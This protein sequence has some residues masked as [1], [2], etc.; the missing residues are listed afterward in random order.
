MEGHD[1]DPWSSGRDLHSCEGDRSRREES[2]GD[3]LCYSLPLE[4]SGEVGAIKIDFRLRNDR[5][6]DKVPQQQGVSGCTTTFRRNTRE[7]KR[8]A[9]TGRSM[10]KR[11]VYARVYH[12]LQSSSPATIAHFLCTMLEPL[13]LCSTP[14]SLSPGLLPRDTEGWAHLE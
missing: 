5:A 13:L 7:R 4:L 14:L 10:R 11:L 12:S 2:T 1:G 3:E 8:Q 9:I 6:R